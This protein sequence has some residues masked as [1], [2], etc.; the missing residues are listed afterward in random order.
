M[1]DSGFDCRISDN[2]ICLPAGGAS[3]PYGIKGYNVTDYVVTGNRIK[4]YVGIRCEYGNGMMTGNMCQGST[5][6]F[7]GV[8][9]AQILFR[10]RNGTTNTTIGHN[11]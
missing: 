5:T 2:H 10:D 8:A 6:Y 1:F 4:A 11:W 9:A 7:A 3:S